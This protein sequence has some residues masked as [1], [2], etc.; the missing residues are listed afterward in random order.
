MVY[1]SYK[2]YETS[3]ILT[4]VE[5]DNYRTIDIE[6][7]GMEIHSYFKLILSTIFCILK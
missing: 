4:S 2:E 5:A 1:A 7:P 3:P 6:F